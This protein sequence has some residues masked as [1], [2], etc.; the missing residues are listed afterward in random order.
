MMVLA[1]L[2]LWNPQFPVVLGLAP[3][4]DIPFLCLALVAATIQLGLNFTFS[5]TLASSTQLSFSAVL[6]GILAGSTWLLWLFY[7]HYSIQLKIWTAPHILDSGL[8]ASLVLPLPFVV[9]P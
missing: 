3:L 9:R 5:F 6:R 8:N 2:L 1:L 4:A 7:L